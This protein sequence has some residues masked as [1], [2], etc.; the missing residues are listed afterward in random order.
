MALP[1]SGKI[2]MSMVNEELKKS[3]TSKISLDQSDVR[4][5]ANK[6]S[7]KIA[8]SDL[9]GKSSQEYFTITCEEIDNSGSHPETPDEWVT[10]QVSGY[11]ENYLNYGKFG[12][13]SKNTINS[14]KINGL[15]LEYYDSPL[16][17]IFFVYLTLEMS[18]I[19]K[20]NGCKLIIDSIKTPITM[21]IQQQLLK[22]DVTN[23]DEL[24]TQLINLFYKGKKV[25]FTIKI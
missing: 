4:S 15:Y 10:E 7:G 3:G 23:N 12:S 14:D 5:L 17:G 11:C 20:Y 13:I 18:N 19:S 25:T 8:M 24:Q 21:G 22:Y 1:Q 2:S 9:Y 6:P 16:D